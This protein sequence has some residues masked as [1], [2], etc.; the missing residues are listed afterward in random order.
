MR[1]VFSILLK[2]PCLEAGKEGVLQ[3]GCDSLVKACS[4]D[5]ARKMEGFIEVVENGNYS[6]GEVIAPVDGHLT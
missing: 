2:S 4:L 6:K 3:V 5:E 1:Q